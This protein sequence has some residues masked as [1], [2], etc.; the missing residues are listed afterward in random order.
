MFK[1]YSNH[2]HKGF[3]TFQ[4]GVTCILT[5]SLNHLWRSVS[6]VKGQAKAVY[7][8]LVNGQ[9]HYILGNGQRRIVLPRSSYLCKYTAPVIQNYM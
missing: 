4:R 8:C 3:K 6:A 9:G 2:S 5:I 7:L 1:G